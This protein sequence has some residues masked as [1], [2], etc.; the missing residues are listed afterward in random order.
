MWE[1]YLTDE[2]DRWLD[3]LAADDPEGHRQAVYAIE[4][5]AEGGPNLVKATGL[6]FTA[7]YPEG[8][9]DHAAEVAPGSASGRLRRASSTERR[10][11]ARPGAAW[12]C[13]RSGRARP[14]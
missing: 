8:G 11:W 12:T 10:R 5:L 4:A 1:I 13:R 7:A 14:A 9:N 6:V 3:R 2:V